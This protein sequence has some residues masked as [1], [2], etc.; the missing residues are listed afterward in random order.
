M[1]NR[2]NFVI[3]MFRRTAMARTIEVEIDKAG[4]VHPVTPGITLPQGR[5]ILV[6]D[7]SEEDMSLYLAEPAL[8]DWL[9]PEED[10]A[11]AQWQPVK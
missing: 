11:W 7:A 2:S 3:V 8:S 9:L 5:A 4:E 1:L 10:A 6:W